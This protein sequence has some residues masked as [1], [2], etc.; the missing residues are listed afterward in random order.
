[1]NG[2][3]I[4]FRFE[5]CLLATTS[6]LA[7]VG[8]GESTSP[9]AYACVVTAHLKRTLEANK[10]NRLYNIEVY[11]SSE[12]LCGARRHYGIEQLQENDS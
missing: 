9:S 4:A 2:E 7:G 11:D 5:S 8:F 3:C 6:L 10:A 1:M 12:P